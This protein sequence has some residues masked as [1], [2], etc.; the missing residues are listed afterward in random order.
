MIYNYTAHFLMYKNIREENAPRHT[1][2]IDLI[3]FLAP[4]QF[5]F[6]QAMLLHNKPL[7]SHPASPSFQSRA[8]SSHTRGTCTP[9]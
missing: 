9:R 2:Q 7:H 8:F 6:P 5:F 1:S 3:N 4:L